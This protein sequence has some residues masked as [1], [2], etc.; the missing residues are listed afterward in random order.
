[1]LKS[2]KEFQKVLS[3]GSWFAGDLMSL[4]LLPTNSKINQLGIAV[5]KK[6]SKSSVKRNRVKRLLKESYR[7]NEARICKGFFVVILFK[8]NVEFCNINYHVVN[9]DLCKCLKKANILLESI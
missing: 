5:G 9:K 4:Y 1:M 8:S 7:L 6:F 2:T 3:K